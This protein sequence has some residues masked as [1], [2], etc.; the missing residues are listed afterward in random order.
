MFPINV[1][2]P[3]MRTDWRVRAVA[4]ALCLVATAAVTI[5][6]VMFFAG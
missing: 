6:L 2:D 5:A 4:I 3:T 1:S